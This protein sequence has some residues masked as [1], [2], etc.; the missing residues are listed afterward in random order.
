MP[1]RGYRGH[2]GRGGRLRLGGTLLSGIINH[3]SICPLEFNRPKRGQTITEAGS[4]V[5]E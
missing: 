4:N 5:I 2:E 1:L 3:Y